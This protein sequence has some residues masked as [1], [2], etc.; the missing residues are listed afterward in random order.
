MAKRMSMPSPMRAASIQMFSMSPREQVVASGRVVG[1]G[2][3]IQ[4]YYLPTTAREVETGVQRLFPKNK[5]ISIIEY[6]AKRKSLN[7]SPSQYTINYQQNFGDRSLN[8]SP[9]NM[10]KGARITEN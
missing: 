5:R 4:G 9:S 1:G 8:R 6:E 3:G 2:V 7:P 10:P